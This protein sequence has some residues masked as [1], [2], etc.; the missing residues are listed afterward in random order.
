M[1]IDGI[2]WLHW[3]K[4]SWI[5]SQLL[6]YPSI[7]EL[8]DAALVETLKC[9]H[10]WWFQHVST[11]FGQKIGYLTNDGYF[12]N[13]FTG[14][15]FCCTQPGHLLLAIRCCLVPRL[16]YLGHQDCL[17]AAKFGCFPAQ[18]VIENSN[19][20]SSF[21]HYSIIIQSIQVYIYIYY[22]LNY[23]MS[24]MFL[25]VFPRFFPHFSMV[26]MVSPWFPPRQGRQVTRA[27]PPSGPVAW[28][29]PRGDPSPLG[30]ARSCGST[31]RHWDD[32]HGNRGMIFWMIQDD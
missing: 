26:P 13:S 14:S 10:W 11:R 28:P 12:T 1:E 31:C 16:R 9:W 24:H 30:A 25:I 21:P 22:S 20:N 3:S 27:S 17:Q 23:G 7:S 6:Q 15:F 8:V 18:T 5:R 2:R 32:R 19:S 4:W 29:R